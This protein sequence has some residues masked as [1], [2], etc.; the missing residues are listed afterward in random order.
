VSK[1]ISTK[2]LEGANPRLVLDAA[3]LKVVGGPDRGMTIELS[4][5]ILTIGS[6][7]R[8]DLVLH[9]PTVSGRH[10]EVRLTARGYVISDLGSTN[11]LRAGALVVERALLADGLRLDVGESALAVRST[12]Q[13]VTVP[14]VQAGEIG[15]LVAQSVKMRAFMATLMQL[16]GSDATVLIEGETGTGKELAAQALHQASAR[17]SG[18]FVTFDCSTA[19]PD[20]MQSELFGHERGAFS[21]A[22]ATRRGLFE[23]AEGGTLF[24]DEVAELPRDVQP[25]LLGVL[26][27]KRSR[28]VGGKV[29]LVHDVRLVASTQRNLG[30]EVRKKTFRQ[31][32][33]Y[34][35]NVGQ[36]K[37]PPLRERREDLPVLAEQFA[38][39]AGAELSPE[40]LAPLEAYEWPGNVRELQN[41]IRRMAIERRVPDELARK[42]RK[43]SPH[44]YDERGAILPWL[45]ARDHAAE[46]LE[47]D[48]VIEILALNKGNLS[49]AAEMAGITRQ[50]LTVLALKHGLHPRAR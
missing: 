1:P 50:S 37:M 46:V 28:R 10:A 29:D 6:S 25:L 27:R 35:L 19:K 44:L 9:D 45:V 21:G 32:L 43:R 38:R 24:L 23:E 12:G 15:G 49:H 4:P 11:G 31:D 20:L 8:C 47:R 33:F 3:E 41:I 34:R 36:L 5:Q 18:P 26:E 7:S 17:R 2:I 16:A 13:K 22:S 40:Q 39:E 48:Y 30:E 42:P 14:L